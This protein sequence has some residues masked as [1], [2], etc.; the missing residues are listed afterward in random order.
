MVIAGGEATVAEGISRVKNK[1]KQHNIV[2]EESIK[3]QNT[4]CEMYLADI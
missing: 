3:A 1:F 4:A 2:A